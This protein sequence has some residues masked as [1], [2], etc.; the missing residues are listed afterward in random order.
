MVALERVKEY[1][2]LKREPAEFVEPRPAASWPSKGQIEVQDLVVRYA[3][4][5]LPSCNSLSCDA[6]VLAIA[7]SPR[8]I[9]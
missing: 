4:S 7:R 8:C 1:S 3:V 2:V 6:Q 9:A 5:I